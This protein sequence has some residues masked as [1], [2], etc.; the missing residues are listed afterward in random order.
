MDLNQQTT[1][2]IARIKERRE[3]L[4]TCAYYWGIVDDHKHICK[5]VKN[6]LGKAHRCNCGS[7]T[8][9]GTK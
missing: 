4:G 9:K 7:T 8:N 5:L 2:R 6:H 1:K 3:K